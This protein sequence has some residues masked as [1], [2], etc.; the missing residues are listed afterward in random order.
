[1]KTLTCQSSSQTGPCVM[2]F[3]SLDDAVKNREALDQRLLA[4]PEHNGWGY[5]RLDE[6]LKEGFEED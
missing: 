5:L 4:L 1:M 3:K 6:V 2:V